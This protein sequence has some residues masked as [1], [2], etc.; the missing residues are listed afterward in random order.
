MHSVPFLDVK[1]PSLLNFCNFFLLNGWKSCK[2]SP[3]SLTYGSQAMCNSKQYR[4][5]NQRAADSSHFVISTLMHLYISGCNPYYLK[6][7]Y[8]PICIVALVIG[9]DRCWPNTPVSVKFAPTVNICQP[10]VLNK[11]L[12]IGDLQI[13][14][15]KGY[16]SNTTSI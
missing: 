6:E 14:R 10:I 1:V 4:H 5:G 13:F 9:I 2:H 8:I 3:T 7:T 15:Y 16:C 12:D 11:S